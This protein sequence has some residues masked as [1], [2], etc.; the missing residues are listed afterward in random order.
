MRTILSSNFTHEERFSIKGYFKSHLLPNHIES[1]K[2][3]ILQKSCG[4]NIFRLERQ[5]CCILKSF[6]LIHSKN[7]FF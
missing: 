2:F 3:L 5:S 6:W 4:F 7:G 1:T